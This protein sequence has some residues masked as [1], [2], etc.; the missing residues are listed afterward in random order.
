MC[1][2]KR[3]QLFKRTKIEV[4]MLWVITPESQEHWRSASFDVL[5]PGPIFVKIPIVNSN[6]SRV[7]G[8][9]LWEIV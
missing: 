4:M 9:E 1:P 2:G 3:E 8:M 5:T 6:H 7:S